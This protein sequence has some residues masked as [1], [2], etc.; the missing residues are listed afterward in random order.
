MDKGNIS[1]FTL[2]DFNDTTSF[3]A[4][5]ARSKVESNDPSPTLYQED[6]KVK[7]FAEGLVADMRSNVTHHNEQVHQAN[8]GLQV[9]SDN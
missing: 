2:G 9:P 3:S 4:Q 7:P 6:G 1:G 8:T 5:T